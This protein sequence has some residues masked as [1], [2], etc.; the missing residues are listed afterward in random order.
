MFYIVCHWW[1]KMTKSDWFFPQIWTNS[2]HYA[3]HFPQIISI[4]YIDFLQFV[5]TDIFLNISYLILELVLLLPSLVTNFASPK[6]IEIKM[7]WLSQAACHRHKLHNFFAR[8]NQFLGVYGKMKTAIFFVFPC[9]LSR[10]TLFFLSMHF[11]WRKLQNK[12][13]FFVF[14]KKSKQAILFRDFFHE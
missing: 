9:S 3:N 12:I 7:K 10:C 14:S 4:K 1:A 6:G 5:S 2:I 8:L 13:A 11:S